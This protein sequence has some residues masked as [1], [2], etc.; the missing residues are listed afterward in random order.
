MSKLRQMVIK[1]PISVVCRKMG[2]RWGATALEFDIVGTGKTK[3][4]ALEGMRELFEDYLSSVVEELRA[5]NEVAFF[6]PSDAED[7]NR[8]SIERYELLC[9][10]TCAESAGR[11]QPESP[12][13]L[14]DLRK[15]THFIDSLDE[16]DVK[17]V[18]A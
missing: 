2:A 13:N 1:W 15:L 4:A 3:E 6:N 14:G 5:G 11:E 16:V 17:P 10:V 7:W 9:R 12:G 18:E 8:D